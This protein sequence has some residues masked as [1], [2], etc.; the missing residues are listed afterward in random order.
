M[1]ETLQ[2]NG[3]HL[4]ICIGALFAGFILGMGFGY[5]RGEERGRGRWE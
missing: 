5:I 3:A 4:L 1:S 2:F